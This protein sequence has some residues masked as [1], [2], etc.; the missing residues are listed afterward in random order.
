MTPFITIN[1]E[2][3]D[4]EHICCAFSDKKCQ[5][6]Y[7]LK[8]KWLK[9]EFENGYT[10]YRLNERAKVFIEYGPI[11]QA[12]LPIEGENFINI[13]CFWVSGKYKGNG[14]GKALLQKALDDA[15]K[16]GKTGLVTVV[17]KKKNHFMSEG[18]WF[19]RQGFEVVDETASGFMLLMKKIKATEKIPIFKA[20]TKRD[21]I[22]NKEGITVY[23][24]N[25]CPFTDY[26]VET[27]LRETLKYRGIPFE[28]NKITTLEEAKQAPTP[29]TIFSLYYK[30]SFITTD[31]SVC[32]ED[33]FEKFWQKY[34]LDSY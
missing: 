19:L 15:E 21:Y 13:N 23:Y 6:S 16:T 26:H 14:Y 18:K 20:Q 12:W 7:E 5:E 29:A 24:S 4:K 17:G 3:I 11:E 28:I 1:Q 22:E 2:N 10:F 9:S 30:G 31:L 33:R 27:E 8:K 32:R 34:K 25:R